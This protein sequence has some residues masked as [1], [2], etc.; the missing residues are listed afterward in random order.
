MIDPKNM[1]W[2]NETGSILRLEEYYVK[3]ESTE[4]WLD[5]MKSIQA[6]IPTTFG[7]EMDALAVSRNMQVLSEQIQIFCFRPVDGDT[8]VSRTFQA[9][10]R[11][12]DLEKALKVSLSDYDLLA[13][14]FQDLATARTTAMIISSNHWKPTLVET[15]L[16]LVGIATNRLM[17]DDA[18]REKL[19]ALLHEVYQMLWD[20]TRL[21]RDRLHKEAVA[22]SP[23]PSFN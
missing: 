2:C 22:R 19:I 17:A 20:L 3:L 5:A 8:E 6:S 16:D 9:E 11:D 23:K 4:D 7:T 18:P 12:D 15:V 1:S 13:R 10:Y 21:E 14:A